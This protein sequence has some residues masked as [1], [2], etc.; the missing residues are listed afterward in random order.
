MIVLFVALKGGES[1]GGPGMSEFAQ[2][3]AE[4]F[5]AVVALPS[6]AEQAAYLNDVCGQNMD[7]RSEVEQLLKY[8]HADGSFLDSPPAAMAL[9]VDQ[10]PE[11]P[12]GWNEPASGA[13]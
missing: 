5:D 9:T 3:A 6:A 4:I 8:D 2:Q 13:I 7:L 11:R 1:A 12:S 10:R